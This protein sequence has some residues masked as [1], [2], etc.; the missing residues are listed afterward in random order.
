MPISKLKSD[1]FK[2]KFWIYSDYFGINFLILGFL[3]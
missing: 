2:G 3:T 1:Y